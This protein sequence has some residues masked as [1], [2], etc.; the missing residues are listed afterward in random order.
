MYLKL[1][2]ASRK[3]LMHVEYLDNA[4]RYN[5]DIQIL[6]FLEMVGN[7]AMRKSKQ[8]MFVK[9]TIFFSDLCNHNRCWQLWIDALKYPG[10]ILG[11][12]AKNYRSWK[13][14]NISERNA[15]TLSVGM[16]VDNAYVFFI[17]VFLIV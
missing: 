3:K 8:R 17:Y 10:R 12:Y 13:N 1:N 9:Y 7:L 2:L 6:F 4:Q 5:F 11:S 14:Y 15:T 16:N